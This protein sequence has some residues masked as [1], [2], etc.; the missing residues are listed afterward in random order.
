MYAGVFSHGI[1]IHFWKKT[2][3]YYKTFV[4]LDFWGF[5]KMFKIGSPTVRIYN[6][7]DFYQAIH[8]DLTNFEQ[9]LSTALKDVL[10]RSWLCDRIIGDWTIS[11]LPKALR[12]Q[13]HI[14]LYFVSHLPSKNIQINN[15][16][17]IF[18]L[19]KNGFRYVWSMDETN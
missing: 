2:I 9:H 4:C 3:F 8:A 19:E 6:Q 17:F 5:S 18:I 7:T 11:H 16:S 14:N 13:F 1:F 15:N 12:L 10:H